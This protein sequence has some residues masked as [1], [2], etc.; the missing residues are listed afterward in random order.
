MA[1]PPF[2]LVGMAEHIQRHQ[3]LNLSNVLELPVNEPYFSV[4]HHAPH[5]QRHLLGTLH[6]NMERIASSVL[7][8]HANRLM[9]TIGQPTSHES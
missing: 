9:Q 3:S 6:P 5:V 8:L 7:I 4:P 1:T 2:T